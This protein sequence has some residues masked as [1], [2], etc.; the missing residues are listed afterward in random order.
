MPDYLHTKGDIYF[1]PNVLPYVSTSEN[2]N[3]IATETSL[4][5]AWG[6]Q[7]FKI[8]TQVVDSII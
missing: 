5:S 1:Y 8:S 4:T 2:A 3:T 7:V 6:W